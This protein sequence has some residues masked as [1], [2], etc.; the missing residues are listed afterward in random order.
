[1]SSRAASQM[2]QSGASSSKLQG[3]EILLPGLK[4]EL[5]RQIIFLQAVNG[6]T[7]R[8]AFYSPTNPLLL[9]KSQPAPAATAHKTNPV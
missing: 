5:K 8:S 1:M 4:T 3:E 9:F 2:P 6:L 7:F